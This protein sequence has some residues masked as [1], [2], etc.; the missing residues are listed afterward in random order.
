VVVD[1]D[2]ERTRHTM[3]IEDQTVDDALA[4][5][6]AEEMLETTKRSS[7]LWRE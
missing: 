2:L 3:A 6:L 4:E 1:R 7:A 5:L